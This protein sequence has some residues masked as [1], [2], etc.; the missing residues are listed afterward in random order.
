METSNISQAAE[1]TASTV[2][3]HQLLGKW[4]QALSKSMRTSVAAQSI[5]SC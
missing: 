1:A 4:S 5:S 3:G 2:Q